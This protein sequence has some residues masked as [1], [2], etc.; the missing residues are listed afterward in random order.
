MRTTAMIVAILLTAYLLNFVV[1]SIGLTDQINRMITA[2]N[3]SPEALPLAVVT[4]YVMFG[5][6]MET[7]PV[8]V[9]PFRS[10]HRR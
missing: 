9:R 7:S 8:M 10:S 5:M 2:L 3:L 1:T 6:F 4:F